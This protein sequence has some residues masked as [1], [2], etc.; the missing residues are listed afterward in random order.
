MSE[1]IL[2]RSREIFRWLFSKQGLP[3][4]IPILAL[5]AS[6]A[7]NIVQ[8]VINE[9]K[10]DRLENSYQRAGTFQSGDLMDD[11]INQARPSDEEGD[12]IRAPLRIIAD[13]AG[14]GAFSHPEKFDQYLDALRRRADNGQNI[15]SAIFLNRERQEEVL[16]LQFKDF[17]ALKATEPGQDKIEAFMATDYGR[18]ALKDLGLENKALRPA[19]LTLDEWV[20][21]ILAVEELIIADLKGWGVR[22]QT[23]P[24]LLTV[25]MWSGHE[26]QALMAI[27]DFEGVVN[28]TGFIATG[29]ISEHVRNIFEIVQKGAT[30]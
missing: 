21:T 5:I 9:R 7:F 14:Y 3:T 12:E 27:V 22:V 4:L 1:G 15:V 28:E 25:H 29:Y 23:Y 20:Q 8:L 19:E 11:I 16:R 6:V 10:E 13:L 26:D 2:A 17:D 30:S 24:H 18:Q